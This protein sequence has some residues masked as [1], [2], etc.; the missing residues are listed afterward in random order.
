MI[1]KKIGAFIFQDVQNPNETKTTAVTLRLYALILSVY[2]LVLFCVCCF[3]RDVPSSLLTLICS[4]LYVFAFRITYLNH[5]HFAS[6]FSQLLTLLWITVFIQRFGWD[7]GVQH[8]LFVL[9]VLNFAVSF[10][11]I[12]TKIFVGICTC[13]YRLLLYSYTRYHLPVFQLS[14][15]SSICIQTIDTLFI[16]AE[17]I[18]VMI[19]FTQNSQQME[20]KLMRY[21]L[22]LEH[23]ASTDP[24]TGLFNRWQMYKRLE[25]CI[26]RYTQHKLQ[27]LTVAMGDI[28]FFKHVNDTYGHDAGDEVLRTLS[29]LFCT[30]IGEKGEVCRWGG[31][32]FLFVFPG[33][34][35]E[36]VQ[37]LMSDL[38]DDIRHTPVLYERE[39]IHV[40]MTFGVE[41]FGRNH[42]ME[43]VIQE[44]DRKL[45]L[46]KESGRNR[47]IYRFYAISPTRWISVLFLRKSKNL[48]HTTV[49]T[50]PVTLNIIRSATAVPA[51]N[52]PD[53]IDS[54]PNVLNTVCHAYPAE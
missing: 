10:H 25:T 35:M 16:F 8:F 18:T 40:T 24:L 12:R 11:R 38:L 23:I 20:H 50:D 30:V 28:D 51:P 34:D 53:A 7:C 1:H 52:N 13:A 9:L 47:V 45:Y 21:N 27:T 54:A 22:E 32:E 6:I 2:F 48:S 4:I 14:T 19:I 46:G 31:E 3:L 29:R 33:M 42:T 43:S 5:T 49:Y 17:L 44:A 15:D 37:L 36:E 26:S 41:E 39:L